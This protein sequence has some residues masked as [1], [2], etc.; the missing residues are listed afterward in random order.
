MNEVNFMWE[1]VLISNNNFQIKSSIEVILK[2]Q[3]HCKL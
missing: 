3:L 2:I 1:N